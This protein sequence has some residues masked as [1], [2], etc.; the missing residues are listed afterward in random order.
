MRKFMSTL[1]L[2][3]ICIMLSGC[4]VANKNSAYS[5]TKILYSTD[6]TNSDFISSLESSAEEYAIEKNIELHVLNAEGLIEKQ[7]EHIKA[8]KEEG[9]SAI[10]CVPVDK[11]T[12]LQLID[13]ADG[14]P[15][16]F[17]NKSPNTDLLEPNKYIYVGSDENA[18]GEIQADYLSEYFGNKKDIK[19]VI[20][21]GPSSH[22]ASKL[23]TDSVK[24]ALKQKGYNVDYV[25]EDSASWLTDK[26]KD[27][28]QIFLDTGAPFD[29][30]ISNNDEMALGVIAAGKEKGLDFSK[31]PIV[32]VDAISAARSAISEGTLAL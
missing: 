2:T 17:M 11:D 9:Y 23:R 16:V 26:A 30:V 13:V 7:I 14:L 24:R 18:V 3:F 27:M 31:L 19:V 15:I 22:P 25:F 21:K 20:M 12:A 1:I 28:F 6:G 32:G 8:A 10:I 5:N 29:A 4:G